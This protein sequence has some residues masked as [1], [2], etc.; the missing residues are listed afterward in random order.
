SPLADVTIGAYREGESTPVATA[1]S[2]ST[3]A[4]T[5]TIATNGMALDGYLLGMKN[6]YKD[7]YL[8]PPTPLVADTPNATVLML[9]QGNF[10]LAA[11]LAGANQ[12]SGQGFI[13]IQLYDAASNP[14]ADATISSTP[15]GTVRYNTNGLPSRNATM[16][17]SD[18][19][20]YVFSVAPGVVTV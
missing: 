2:D 19:I 9:T 18:G 1:T 16:S 17:A 7:T 13:G 5:L 3:G 6:G 20:G 11:T 15:A 8:Y 10:D 14:V 4:Y 12:S